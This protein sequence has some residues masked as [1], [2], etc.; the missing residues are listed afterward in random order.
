M[1]RSLESAEASLALNRYLV[2]RARN[3]GLSKIV[4]LEQQRLSG[5]RRLRVGAAA[6][7]GFALHIGHVKHFRHIQNVGVEVNS[8]Q[9]LGD[10]PGQVRQVRIA[11]VFFDFNVFDRKRLDFGVNPL[12]RSILFPASC[13]PPCHS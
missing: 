5:F 11:D 9:A 2:R 12:S 6:V 1:Q 8:V 3:I 7:T 13:C 10:L 4:A